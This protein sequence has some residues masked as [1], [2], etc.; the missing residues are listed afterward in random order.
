MSKKQ[1]MLHVSSLFALAFLFCTFFLLGGGSGLKA[2]TN[3]LSEVNSVVPASRNE[4]LANNRFDALR[5]EDMRQQDERRREQMQSESFR[6]FDNTDCANISASESSGERSV[7]HPKPIITNNNKNITSGVGEVSPAEKEHRKQRIMRQKR[8]QLE[9][10]LGINLSDYGYDK[11]SSAV[12]NEELAQEEVADESDSGGFFSLDD[13]ADSS[14]GDIKAVIHGDHNNLTSGSMVKMRILDETVIDGVRI[15]KNT[16]V[17]GKLTFKSGRGMINIQNINYR[18]KILKFNGS[19]YDQDGFEGIYIPDNIIDETQRKAA[20][21]AVGGVDIKVGSKAKAINSAVSAVGNA[22]K[23][24][25][26]GSIKES[27]ISISSNY[28]ITIKKK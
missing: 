21:D 9:N 25:V 22:I 4:V 28:V 5:K 18:N 12:S 13:M 8:A 10:E 11:Y 2:E 14:S 24:A 3:E 26:K 6:I 1:K 27:K 17:Y 23:S 20:S 7:E 19:I 16:F 15:P